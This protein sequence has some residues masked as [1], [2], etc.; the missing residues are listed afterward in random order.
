MGPRY[1][2]GPIFGS[3]TWCNWL[4]TKRFWDLT[5]V[6]LTD[7]DTNSIQT[8]DANKAIQGNVAMHLAPPGGQ[9]CNWC[10]QGHLMAKFATDARSPTC[11]S[12]L[13]L[14]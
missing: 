11:W 5:D 4:T 2:W 3:W 8:D 6:T 12:N 7:E 13:Q 14:M 1:T 10:K 9:I